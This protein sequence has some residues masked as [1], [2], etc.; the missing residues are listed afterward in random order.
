MFFAPD[1]ESPPPTAERYARSRASEADSLRARQGR[2]RWQPREAL[3]GSGGARGLY[4]AEARGAQ[5]ARH[6]VPVAF[7]LCIACRTSEW[8]LQHRRPSSEPGLAQST[9]RAPQRVRRRVLGEGGGGGAQQHAGEER[10]ES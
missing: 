8:S 4:L 10:T 5:R 9:L 3:R 2:Q 1:R 7:I 6:P